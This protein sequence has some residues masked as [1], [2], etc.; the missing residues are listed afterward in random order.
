[1]YEAMLFNVPTIIPSDWNM[2]SSNR[3]N[4]R[5]IK[6]SLDAYS[7]CPIENLSKEVLY[8]LKNKKKINKIIEKQK[9][10]HFSYIK[11]SS[12]KVLNLMDKIITGKNKE[13]PIIK[14]KKFKNFFL[15]ILNKIV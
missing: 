8:I 15:K 9:N 10:S 7:S 11:K 4:P 12:D 13:K 1:M 2:R 14:K 3:N 5:K 6:P